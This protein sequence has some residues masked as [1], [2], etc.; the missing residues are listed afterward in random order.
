MVEQREPAASVASVV[1][2]AA[3][4]TALALAARAAWRAFRAR[5][6]ANSLILNETLPVHS[7]WWRDHAKTPGEVL[8]VALGD[9]AAQGIGAS[10]PDRSYVGVLARDIRRT[11]GRSVRVVNLSVSGATVDLAVRD[12]LPKL[13]KLRPDVM[14]VAIGAN[15]IAEWDEAAFEGG[16]RSVFAALPPH[17]L[18]ADL[19]YFYFPRNE[20]KVAVANR[21]VRA[22]AA[23]H[24]L[25]VVPLHD[26]TRYQGLRRMF[27][28]F[29]M[30]WFHPNDH[31]Y[32]VWAAA[33]RPSL[34]AAL[35]ARFPAEPTLPPE[36]EV[37]AADATTAVAAH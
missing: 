4:I 14:T 30:D 24:G 29:A 26:E 34:V 5:L 18:V 9:S 19:P 36:P 8:Y 20:R 21:I 11:T 37:P 27:T 22:V 31:G 2:P 12:Q 15:D 35:V 6:T 17:A 13:A 23:E 10:R 3:L 28:H 32:R 16:I 1:V 7:K 25:T 33:F